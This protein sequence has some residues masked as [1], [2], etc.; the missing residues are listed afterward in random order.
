MNP[1]QG[2]WSGRFRSRSVDGLQ[3][4]ATMITAVRRMP[5]FSSEALLRF[6]MP[7]SDAIGRLALAALLALGLSLLSGCGTP[8][9]SMDELVDRAA[10]FCD[11]GRGEEA[12]FLLDQVIAQAPNQPR[13]FYLKGLA[14]ELIQEYELARQAYDKCLELTPDNSDALNNRGVVLAR[15]GMMEEAIEDLTKATRLNP[16]DALAWSNLALAYHERGDYSDA[17]SSYSQA[18]DLRRDARFLQQMGSV[19]LE[20]KQFEQAEQMFDESLSLSSQNSHGYLHRANA[21]IEQEK[22]EEALEDLELAKKFDTDKS[23]LSMIHESRSRI[24]VRRQEAVPEAPASDAS[25][26]AAQMLLPVV[27]GW[28]ARQGWILE[29]QEAVLA[30]IVADGAGMD[31]LSIY[32]MSGS[33]SMEDSPGAAER[34]RLILLSADS[35]GQIVC[36]YRQ[37][38]DALQSEQPLALVAVDPQW[39]SHDSSIEEGLPA[40]LIHADFSWKPSRRDFI[41]KTVIIKDLGKVVDPAPLP[42]E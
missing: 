26:V 22:F 40:W 35:D 42:P 11:G 1:K 41:S 39:I 2:E 28:L 13:P 29:N 27:T 19:Y 24:D 10:A 3:Y 38:L 12:L 36:Q 21:R 34:R 30:E 31:G 18:L 8:R 9:W 33:E 25:E 14:H 23:L 7:A 15:L 37:A 20:T 16:Q 17:L 5:G 6:Q 4:Q 32:K